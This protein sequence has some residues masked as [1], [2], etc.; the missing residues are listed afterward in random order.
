MRDDTE[1]FLVG[2]PGGQA[3][4]VAGG[5]VAVDDALGRHLVDERLSEVSGFWRRRYLWHRE[6][7]A[8]A[9]RPVR[10]FERSSRLC[11]RRT[12]FCRCAF[13]ADLFFL[14]TV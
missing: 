3:R 5:G 9:L 10:S 1:D 8:T 11:S 13:S 4:L 6:D 7:L 14:A 2:D 12:M